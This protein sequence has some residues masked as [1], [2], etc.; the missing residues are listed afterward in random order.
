MKVRIVKDE[1]VTNEKNDFAT[2]FLKNIRRESKEYVTEE[3]IRNDAQFE[4]AKGIKMVLTN[5]LNLKTVN[6]NNKNE[7]DQETF[8]DYVHAANDIDRCFNNL[9][10]EYFEDCECDD[11]CDCLNCDNDC[12]DCD[13]PYCCEDDDNNSNS[14][15]NAI[16][17]VYPSDEIDKIAE[18]TR[19]SLKQNH[20]IDISLAA[21]IPTIVY[22]FMSSAN[23]FL[24]NND[25]TVITANDICHGPKYIF[26]LFTLI[27]MFKPV[28]QMDN[29]TNEQEINLCMTGEE[30]NKIKAIMD[31]YTVDSDEGSNT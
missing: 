10:E 12:D 19:E 30:Y 18:H 2:E 23:Q 7:I 8:D 5:L 3:E 17:V 1:Q 14:R 4:K 15:P 11:E 20:N 6:T 28:F 25:K 9:L 27:K 16:I 13:C 29:V 21:A 31:T 24:D 26:D 22:E